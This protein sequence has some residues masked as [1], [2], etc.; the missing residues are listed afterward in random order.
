MYIERRSYACP[1]RPRI[2][3]RP[4]VPVARCCAFT[5]PPVAGNSSS[6]GPH[7]SPGRPA[8]VDGCRCH[9][10]ARAAARRPAGASSVLLDA[11]NQLEPDGAANRF[12]EVARL[13]LSC[14]FGERTVNPIYRDV[15]FQHH[16][17]PSAAEGRKRKAA[18]FKRG[19][20]IEGVRHG[21]C[22]C[23]TSAIS[24]ALSRVNRQIHCTADALREAESKQMVNAQLKHV[25]LERIRA[26][27]FGSLPLCASLSQDRRSFGRR[28]L[29]KA[30]MRGVEDCREISQKRR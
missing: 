9:G 25:A 29:P 21:P 10:F 19:K 2:S 12:G 24:R 23:E 17:V 11:V 22:P 14:R 26:T 28:A 6:M 20:S 13:Q 15:R 4:G 8:P 16:V 7:P 18:Q 3:P 30:P 5:L 27:R 1:G